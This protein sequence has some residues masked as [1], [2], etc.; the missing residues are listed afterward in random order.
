MIG[1]GGIGCEILKNLAMYRFKEI[2]ILDLDTI[3]VD[4]IY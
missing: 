1:V 3:E 4:S 2:H